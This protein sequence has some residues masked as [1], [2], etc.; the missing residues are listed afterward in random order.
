MTELH[1]YFDCL[2]FGENI[3]YAFDFTIVSSTGGDFAINAGADAN[4]SSDS[5]SAF[6][7][8]CGMTVVYSIGDARPG[9]F[10][11]KESGQRVVEA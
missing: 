3:L 5:K 2:L 1:I 6:G 11:T 4:V 9:T 7:M 10:Y 8:N